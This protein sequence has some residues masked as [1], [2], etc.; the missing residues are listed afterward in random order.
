MQMSEATEVVQMVVAENANKRLADGWKLLAATSTDS[1]DDSGR[2][3]VWY[4][5]GNPAVKAKGEFRAG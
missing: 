2:T 5:L 1:G 4:V 3:F